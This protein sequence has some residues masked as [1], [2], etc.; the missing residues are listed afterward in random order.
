MS[1]RLHCGFVV[2]KLCDLE[3]KPSFSVERKDEFQLCS[4]DGIGSPVA[5]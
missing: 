2:M 4:V 1:Y 3:Y 5:H